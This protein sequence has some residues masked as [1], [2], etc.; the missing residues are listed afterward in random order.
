MEKTGIGLAR[1]HA[2]NRGSKP[3]SLKRGEAEEA[4]CHCFRFCLNL[5]SVVARSF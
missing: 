5:F 2:D 3:I 4:E 1:T